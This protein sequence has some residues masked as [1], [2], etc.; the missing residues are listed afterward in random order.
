MNRLCVLEI[1]PLSVA[2][3]ASIFFRS[4]GLSFRFFNGLFPLLCQSLEVRLG[5]V[6]LFL[7]LFLSPWETDTGGHFWIHWG[8]LNQEG[9][10]SCKSMVLNICSLV[11][12]HQHPLGT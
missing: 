2:S 5:P 1:E 10:K 12:Q 3:F 6:R 4:V 7:F 8:C 11:G 9:K